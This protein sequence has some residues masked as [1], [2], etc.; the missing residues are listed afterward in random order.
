MVATDPVYLVEPDIVS[1]GF[2]CR[3]RHSTTARGA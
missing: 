1:K 3:E 2:G